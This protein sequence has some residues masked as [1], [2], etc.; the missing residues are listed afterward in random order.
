MNVLKPPKNTFRQRIKGA[1]FNKG[2]SCTGQILNMTKFI[3]YDF[4]K[5]NITGV[6]LFWSESILQY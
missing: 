5:K 2:K 1:A 4:E 6:S 3:D